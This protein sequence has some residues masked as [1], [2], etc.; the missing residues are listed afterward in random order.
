MA[1]RHSG[2]RHLRK[3]LPSN[4]LTTKITK[5][6]LQWPYMIKNT[7][8]TEFTPKSNKTNKQQQTTAIENPGAKVNQIPRVATL[9]ILND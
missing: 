2:S 6:R 7:H 1:G 8:L 3:S 4:Q 5:E 9:Y